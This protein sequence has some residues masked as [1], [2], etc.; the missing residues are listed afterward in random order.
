M[1]PILWFWE[2]AG[3]VAGLIIGIALAPAVDG[4][5]IPLIL[6]VGALACALEFAFGWTYTEWHFRLR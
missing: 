1:H 5:S 6:A 3:F 4:I 2:A